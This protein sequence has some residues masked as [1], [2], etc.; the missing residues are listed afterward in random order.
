M[1]LLYTKREDTKRRRKPRF[2]GGIPVGGSRAPSV[3]Q[4]LINKIRD[5]RRG[6]G[7]GDMDPESPA[8]VG[9]ELR[10]ANKS[11]N[12]EQKSAIRMILRGQARPCPYIIF[13]PPG[14]MTRP[15]RISSVDPLT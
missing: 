8:A 15:R 1:S 12:E 5:S 7:G 9:M 6:E 11:L 4:D 10:W 3:Y 14:K 13:G 2:G